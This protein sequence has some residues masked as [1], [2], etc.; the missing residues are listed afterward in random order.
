[1]TNP[2]APPPALLTWASQVLGARPCV[3]E[4][5][6]PRETSRVWQLVLSGPVRFHLKISPK[7]VMYERET[8]TLRSAAPAL[9]AASAPQLRASSAEHLALLLTAVPGGPLNE[10]MLAPAE[11]ARAYR[12]ASALLGC[13]H[14][15]GDLS[16][17]RR[18]EAEGALQ[19][20]ADGVDGHLARAADRLTAPERKLVRDLAEQLRALPVA[21]IHGDAWDRSL[22][23]STNL[24]E[25]GGID[26]ARS[27]PATVVQDFVVMACSA[28]VGRPNLRAAFLQGYGRNL[29]SEEQ[30]AVACRAAL[31]AVNCLVWGPKSGD[32]GVT[33][34][35]RRTPDRR[36]AGVFA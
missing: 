7:E 3:Q 6:S 28:W 24:Q 25:G 27:R 36:M 5:S 8:F 34:R 11:E 22:M 14:A 16:G 21:F 12:Q 26:F 15:V 10:L 2:S 19:A 20:A 33:V 4:V 23:R 29:N 31:A 30:H 32:P 9:G 18:N 1:M 13:L 35:G 17:P